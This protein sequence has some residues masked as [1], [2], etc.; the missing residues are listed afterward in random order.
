VCRVLFPALPEAGNLTKGQLDPI[1]VVDDEETVRQ[2]A[3]AVLRKLGGYEVVLAANGREAV[4]VFRE[5]NGRF[6]VVL[7]DDARDVR[8]RGIPPSENDSLRC[9]DHSLERL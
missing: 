2:V 1:L 8:R 6:A 4:N 9:P 5:R 3:E 7:L